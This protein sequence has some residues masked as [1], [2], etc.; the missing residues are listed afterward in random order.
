MARP[1]RIEF[2]GATYHVTTRGNA[3]EPI[4]FTDADRRTLLDVLGET[5]ERFRWLCHGYCLM[6]NHYH[7]LVETPEANLSR[8]MRQ[9]NGVYTQ[10]IN[11]R[12]G[13]VGHLFQ[14]RFKAILVDRNNYLVELC[15]YIVLNPVRGGLVSVPEDYVWSSFSATCGEVPAPSW[16]TTDWVLSQFASRRAD[17]RKRYRGFVRDGIGGDSPWGRLQGQVLLGDREFVE[18]LAPMLEPT[19]DI[20][21]V[22]IAQRR[23]HRP[24]LAE[25]LPPV[26]S[27]NRPQRDH[28]VR[29]AHITHRYSLSEIARQTGL[30][31]TSVSRIVGRRISPRGA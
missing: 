24:A 31:Y 25:L 12:T 11:R 10:R 8:G 7:L 27:A 29:E 2:P 13:R 16:L 9:L 1:L 6:G 28:A 17:A 14:G 19:K 26:V 18:R 23:A 20:G 3:R 4:F 5:T 22:P 15:R 30:H 21:E